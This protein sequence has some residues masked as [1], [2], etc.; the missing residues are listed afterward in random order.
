MASMA[1]KIGND[2]LEGK[3][4]E[5]SVVLLD[6]VLVTRDNV[7]EYKGWQAVRE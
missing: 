6:P 1:V 2:I 4:P 3:K 5:K 7:A